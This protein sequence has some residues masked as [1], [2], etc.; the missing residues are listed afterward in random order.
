MALAALAMA[1]GLLPRGDELLLIHVRNHDVTRAREVLA[2]G[3]DYGVSTT[4]SVVAHGE[5]YL[6]EGRVDEALADMEGYIEANPDDADAWAHLATLYRNAQRTHDWTRALGQMYRLTPSDGLA[7]TLVTRFRHSGDEAAE[8]EVL[9]DLVAG[10]RARPDELR[11]SARLDAAFG[12]Y[13]TA[14]SA[15]ESL[16]R[17]APRDFD[18]PSMELYASLLVDAGMTDVLAQHFQTLPLVREDPML[19]VNLAGTM[20]DWGETDAALSLLAPLPSLPTSPVLVQALVTEALARPDYD[21]VERVLDG[22]PRDPKLVAA[23]IS[24]AAWTGDRNRAQQFIARFG[25]DSLVASPMLALELAVERTDTPAALR[26]IDVVD[27]RQP[28]PPETVAALAQFESTLG[29]P[30]RAFDRLVVLARSGRAPEWALFDLATTAGDLGRE[31]EALAVLEPLTSD[32]S[33]ARSAWVQLAIALG[34]PRLIAAWLEA[35]QPSAADTQAL[36]DAYYALSEGHDTRLAIRA[37]R[38]LYAVSDHAEDALLFGQALLAANEPIEALTPLRVARDLNVDAALTFD[39]ALHAA[40]TAGGDVAAELR[41]VFATRL[42]ATGLPEDHR[43]MLVDGLWQAGERGSLHDDIL[44]LARRD[45]DVW[46]SPLVESARARGESGPAIALVSDALGQAA[47]AAAT[48]VERR[49]LLLNALLDLEAPDDAVLPHLERFA[50]DVGGNWVYAYDDRLALGDRASKQIALWTAVGAS[51]GTTAE[52]RRGAASRL[53]ELGATLAAADIIQPLAATAAPSNPDVDLLL[54]LWGPEGSDR[55]REWL[56]SRL[57]GAPVAEQA[58]WMTHLVN[59]GGARD[60]VAAVT[61]LP[62]AAPPAFVE[63]WVTAHRVAGDR[64][65]LVSALDA[66]IAREDLTDAELR[67]A[68]EAAV[69]E[70]LNLQA[71]R[72]YEV[73]AERHPDD[74]D[75]M[76]WLGTLSFYEGRA[77]EAGTWLTAYRAA[78]GDEAEPLYQ[79]G[80][81]ALG[82][83]E[84][85]RARQLFTLARDRLTGPD[86]GT[87]NPG[88]LANVYVRLGERDPARTLFLG[89]LAADPELDHTRADY[90]SA[91]IEWGDFGAADVV[92]AAGG[93]SVDPTALAEVPGDAAEALVPEA[94][95]SGARRLDLLRYQRLNY[96]GRYGQA[97]RIL[98]DLGSRFPADPDVLVARAGFDADRGR[99]PQADAGFQAARSQA[100]E[101]D[102]IRQLLDERA[103]LSAPRV[104]FQTAGRSVRNGWDEETMKAGLEGV[105]TPRLRFTMS[106]ERLHL[107]APRLLQ[108]SGK[109]GAV[110]AEQHRVEV[111]VKTPVAVGMTTTATVFASAGGVGAGSVLTRHDLYGATAVTVE[112]GRPFWEFPESAADDGTR[113]RVGIER[114]LRFGAETSGWV[115]ANWNRYR[116][117][118]GAELTSAGFGL[119]VVRTVRRRQPTLSLQYGLDIEHRRSASVVEAADGRTFTPVPLSSREVHVAGAISRFKAAIW[120]VE[121]AVGYTVDR[122][123]GH[124]SFLTARMT[125]PAGA[126]VGAEFWVERRL[127]SLA[128]TER[129][130]QIGA[131]LRVRF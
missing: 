121:A 84:K 118:S 128:T 117:G 112:R 126:R 58:A 81:L 130:L 102:D 48:A 78:G 24:Q 35:G 8:A 27:A 115:L 65:A 116:L 101:R 55:Q 12:R 36:R 87:G 98:D 71:T 64:G 83:R 122:L 95:P 33:S 44:H 124:G 21:L 46:L 119:G 37:A 40:L 107:T 77:T 28:V 109:V 22:H 43:A 18:V 16:R 4:A 57:R 30:A 85:Q 7:R 82:R 11:R 29:Y 34:Q 91:L 23:A 32:S 125:P 74:L 67:L 45:L 41:T 42:Q 61:D 26:W 15:L 110:D 111:G 38:L 62:G 70:G 52:D 106:A 19:L 31:D 80:E 51:P 6:F 5:L 72:A 1:A 68:A 69:A 90:V 54:F 127:Y 47:T 97:L 94:D 96:R 99:G 53:H 120:D 123:G 105:L 100:P 88:L 56:V 73:V 129:V 9:R 93:S 103:R 86:A 76:R 49:E 14:R 10:G 50:L 66:V 104:S 13:E 59:A 3:V 63:A 39:A 92:L 2:A 75:A 108:A 20:R 25:D 60:V 114:Q 79:L 113:D 131:A 89:L 17:G